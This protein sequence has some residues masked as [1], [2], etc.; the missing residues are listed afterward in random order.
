MKNNEISMS[1]NAMIHG[2]MEKRRLFRRE[3]LIDSKSVLNSEIIS[4]KGK[5]QKIPTLYR[6]MLIH[7]HMIKMNE[8][9]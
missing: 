7:F 4:K 3:A 2:E 8:F 9:L 5:N 1:K 6:F